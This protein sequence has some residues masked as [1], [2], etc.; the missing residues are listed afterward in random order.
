MSIDA[1]LD[2]PAVALFSVEDTQ[3]ETA[4]EGAS[5]RCSISSLIG[6]VISKLNNSS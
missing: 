3:L 4:C 2:R 1:R 6:Y 5:Q